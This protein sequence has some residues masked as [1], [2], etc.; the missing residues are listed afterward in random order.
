VKV[1]VA[2]PYPPAPDEAAT[3]ALRTVE[4]LL[5]AGHEVDVISPLPSAADQHG[6][7]A[8][9]AGALLLARRARRYDALHLVVSRRILF[10]PELPR[11]RRI[12][13]S[14]ALSLALRAWPAT[15]ADLGDLSDVPGGGGGLSGRLIWRAIGTIFVSGELVANHAV[16]V[17][18]FPAGRVSVRPSE[19]RRPVPGAPGAAPARHVEPPAALPAWTVTASSSWAEVMAEIAARAAAERA[20]AEAPPAGPR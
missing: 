19:G 16:K 14:V 5:A 9:L 13:D 4:R 20:R 8:G 2:A 12:V 3:V 17:L 10:R 6:P 1:L 7:L 11:F 18:G 15:S